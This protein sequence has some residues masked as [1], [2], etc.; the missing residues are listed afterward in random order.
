MRDQLITHNALFVPENAGYSIFSARS[1]ACRNFNLAHC[2]PKGTETYPKGSTMS[3]LCTPESREEFPKQFLV[4]RERLAPVQGWKQLQ[5]GDYHVHLGAGIGAT[6]VNEAKDR[7]KREILIIGWFSYRSDFYPGKE[8]AELWLEETVEDIYPEL[9]G[10]F[11]VLILEHNQLLCTSD[12]G[13]QFPV[14][15]RTETGE[16]GSTPLVLGWTGALQKVPQSAAAFSRTDGTIWYPFGVTP[17]AGIERL[18]PQQTVV[19][20]KHGVNLLQRQPFSRPFLNVSQM[21][22]MAQ[23][24][25]AALCRS[26]GMLECHLTAGWDS[27]MV[28]SA[29]LPLKN[30]ISYLTYLAKGHTAQVDAEVADHIATRF[31]LSY[32]KLPVKTP[33][34]EDINRWLLRTSECV[35]DSVTGLTRTIVD[36]YTHRY[37]L[38]GVG[39]EVGRAFYW[40]RRDTDVMGLTPEDLL[41][42]LGFAGTGR[43]LSLA[44]KW[45]EPYRDHSRAHILDRAYIDIRLGCWAGP[46]LGGH[47]V[48]KPTLSPFNSLALYE[49]MLALPEDYRLSGGFARDFISQ[50]SPD[51]AR[52]PVNRLTGFRRLRY[53]PREVARILPK[54]AKTRLRRLLPS[55][56]PA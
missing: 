45:L 40:N 47:L 10:R 37:G 55:T 14:V 31:D 29:S 34:Q 13:A 2:L 41:G 49:S 56:A 52:I 39:G 51:L 36:T 48:E 53:L 8:P 44:D 21:Y 16:L 15:Y 38:A 7:T 1:L 20:S 12:A 26:Q 19:L 25:I 5:L 46:S 27:R 43:A 17:Y 35:F 28:L 6:R 42:R 33:R 22:A 9:T 54:G 24:F 32:Q 11:A 18:L 23:D 4:T 50:G 30:R 3:E